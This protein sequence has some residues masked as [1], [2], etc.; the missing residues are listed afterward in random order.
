ML[1]YDDAALTLGLVA[2]QRPQRAPSVLRLSCEDTGEGANMAWEA[3]SPDSDLRLPTC[4]T[5]SNTFLLFL[6]HSV[7]R[8][9]NPRE[10]PTY[11][12]TMLYYTADVIQ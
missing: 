3:D 6:S 10:P 12:V 5:M 1:G 9:Q 11:P 7:P 4:K 2:S 8:S